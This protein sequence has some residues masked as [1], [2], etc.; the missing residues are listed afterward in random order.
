MLLHVLHNTLE[1]KVLLLKSI[2]LKKNSFIFE[3][4]WF[5]SKST[6]HFK[7]SIY[8]FMLLFF[9]EVEKLCKEIMLE[10]QSCVYFDIYANG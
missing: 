1:Q 6:D 3:I 9:L 7:W 10:K 2:I 8:S 4:V 5:F